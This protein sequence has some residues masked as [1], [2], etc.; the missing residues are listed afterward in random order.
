MKGIFAYDIGGSVRPV[1]CPVWDKIFGDLD[2]T[3]SDKAFTASNSLFNEAMYFY[4]SLSGATTEIDSY[5]K[6][7]VFE[8]LWDYGSLVRTAWIDESVFG[9]PI[10]VDGNGVLQQ[11]EVGYDN[12]GTPIDSFAQSGYMDISSGEMFIMINGLIPDFLFKG[13]TS[14]VNVT[15]Y[16]L[17]FPNGTPRTYGPF[18]VTATSPTQYITVR[19]RA[20]QIAIKIENNTLGTYW[21]IGA[22]RYRGA[23]AGRR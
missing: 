19:A 17:D 14:S 21:R 18:T 22:M 11:H 5:V 6:H 16:G 1:L 13:N 20:R 23:P 4:P 10:A 2:T 8:N 7:N 9:N 15:L 12:D 3:N